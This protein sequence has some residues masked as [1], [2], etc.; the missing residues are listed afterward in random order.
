MEEL[1]QFFRIEKV[2]GFIDSAY[3][4]HG[5]SI[6]ALAV[7]TTGSEVISMP[8]LPEMVML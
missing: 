2:S 3:G 7:L 4:R 6:S 8:E 1:D 5:F